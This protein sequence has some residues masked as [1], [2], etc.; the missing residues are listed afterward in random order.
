[1][2]KIY[3][4]KIIRMCKGGAGAGAIILVLIPGICIFFSSTIIWG[5]L[6]LVYAE[7]I[8]ND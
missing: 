2:I 1:M 8:G 5:V 4:I 6:F 3:F 7:E